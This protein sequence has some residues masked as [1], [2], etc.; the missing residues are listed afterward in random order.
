[1]KALVDVDTDR[2]LGFTAFGPEAGEI[3]AV[4]QVAISAGVHTALRDAIVAH[5]TMAGGTH[6]SLLA[7]QAQSGVT[8][9][10]LR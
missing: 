1:M 3:M 6:R 10:K 8:G 2:I 9:G 4:V 7:V 5:P